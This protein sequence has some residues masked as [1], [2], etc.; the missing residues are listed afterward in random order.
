MKWLPKCLKST[1]PYSI[2]VVDNNSTDGT[3]DFIKS[4][5]PDIIV[6]RQKKNR[7]FGQANNIGISMALNNGA[8]YVFLLNQDAYLEKGCLDKLIQTHKNNKDYGILSPTHLNGSGTRLDVGFL[9]YVNYAGDI[10]FYSKYILSNSAKLIYDLPFVNAAGW[11]VSRECLKN[12]GGFDPIFFHYGEDVNFCQRVIYHGLKIGIVPDAKIFHDRENRNN[13]VVI[14]ESEEHF[15]I[16]ERELKIK[17]ANINRPWNDELANLILKRKEEWLNSLLKLKLNKVLLFQKEIILLQRL[18]REI[19][20]SR[21]IN[22][23]RNYNYLN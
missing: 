10:D 6:R 16:M 21:K 7:G 4:N 19:Q 3:T 14:S 1:K 9:N 13:K 23:L 5:H 15:K 18:K 20:T 22:M 11:L 8:D 17:L 12:I 2:I